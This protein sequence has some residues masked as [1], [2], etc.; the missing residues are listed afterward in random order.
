MR[1]REGRDLPQQRPQP[2]GEEEQAQHEQDMVQPFGQDV[3]E[4]HG[5]V[6]DEAGPR[7]G[8]VATAK[9][10]R[11][12]ERARLEIAIIGLFHPLLAQHQRA[13]GGIPADLHGFDPLGQRRREGQPGRTRQRQVTRLG[14]LHPIE[15]GR[16]GRP[17]DEDLDPRRHL[18]PEGPEPRLHGLGVDC[19]Q[20]VVGFG[21]GCCI[22]IGHGTKV[23]PGDIAFEGCLD[24][25]GQ[26]VALPLHVGDRGQHFMRPRQHC[27]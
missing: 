8:L 9:A 18:G 10:D 25:E 21:F 13:E 5:D 23:D 19:A 7:P 6:V 24:R 20:S 12:R 22:G 1:Q 17:V 16:H 27:P 2:G 14:D 4:A 15:F 3:V 26:T 11:I